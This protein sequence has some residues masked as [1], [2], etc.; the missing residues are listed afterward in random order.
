MSRKPDDAT[1]GDDTSIDLTPMLDV[2]F[3]MLIFF[4]V[5]ASFIKEAGFDVNRP[6]AVTPRDVVN[7]G[8]LVAIDANSRIWIDR[9][10]IDPRALRA[11]LERLHAELPGGA[12]VIQADAASLTET[13]VRVMDASRAA[14]I[15]DI[16]I[17]ARAD[18]VH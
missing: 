14:G 2:A 11:N 10:N 12:V 18:A 17:A 15:Y 5:T 7:P 9:R 4:I 8:I 3:I 6:D 1:A 16:S 13:L